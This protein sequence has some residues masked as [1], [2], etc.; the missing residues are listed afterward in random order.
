VSCNVTI[1]A[2]EEEEKSDFNETPFLP[3]ALIAWK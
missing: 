1:K 3:A 2:R